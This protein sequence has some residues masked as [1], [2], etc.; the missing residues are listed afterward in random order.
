MT[1]LTV[2]EAKSHF[3]ELIR[4]SD[5]RLE[6]FLITKQGK[7]AAVVMNADEFGGWLETLE[8]MSDKKA[9]KE[10]RK[11]KKELEL[12]QTKSFKEVVGRA[13]RR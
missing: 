9:L 3:L 7:P 10:I 2:T 8:I 6:R 4:N 1:T 13:Q 12:G 5:K 11:A